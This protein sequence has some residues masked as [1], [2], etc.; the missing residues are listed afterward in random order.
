MLQKYLL[1][2]LPLLISFMLLGLATALAQTTIAQDTARM[3]VKPGYIS[4]KVVN[5]YNVPLKNARVAV[6]GTRDTTSTDRDGMFTI[7]ATAGN[8]L[9]VKAKGFN[10]TNY[11]VSK[12]SRAITIQ[13]GELYIKQ[14]E[15]LSVLYDTIKASENLSAISTVYTNQLTTT[16]AS[17]YTYALPGRLAGLYT[18]QNSGFPGAQTNSPT[19]TGLGGIQ[20]VFNA[21][22]S[23][24][25]NNGQISLQSRGSDNAPITVI[26]GVQR[27]LSSIDPES[28][29]SVS[30]LRDGLSTILLGVNSSNSVLLVTTKR[31]QIGKTLISGTAQYGLQQ[32]LGLPTPLSSFQYGYL[33]NEALLNDG[34]APLYT[35]AD[36]NAYKNQTDIYGHPDVNWFNTL[37]RKTSPL[38]SYKVNITGGNSVAKFIVSLN[39]FNQ[40]GLFKNDSSVPYNTNNG[41]NRYILNSDININATKN[42]NIDLQLFGRVQSIIYPGQPSIG[43]GGLLSTLYSIPNNAYPI[44]NADGSFPGSNDS[45]Y[46]NNIIAQS[47]FSG[48]TNTQNHD[49]LTNLDLKYNLG[50]VLKGLSVRGKGN[51]A[52]NSQ[53]F[54]D[55][56]LQNSVYQFNPVTNGYNVFGKTIAQSNSF[57]NVSNSRYAYGQAALAYNNSFGKNNFNSS[58][59]YDY[60]SV[61]LTYDL[62]RVFQNRAFNIAYNYDG[63]YFATG[64]VNN[65]SDDRYPPGNQSYFFYAGGLG[66]QMGKE[67]FMKNLTWISS[68]KWRATYANTG[69]D[70]LGYFD[71]RAT[72]EGGGNGYPQGTG[73]ITGNGYT[74]SNYIVNPNVRPE[75]AH[76][77]NIGTDI[78]FWDQKFLLTADYYNNRYYDLLQT[79]GKSSL[80]AGVPKFPSENIGINKYEGAEVTLTYQNHLNDFNYFITGNGNISASKRIYSDELQ[81]VYPWLALTGR[82]LR[83]GYGYIAEGFFQSQQEIN[84][85]AKYFNYT[86]KPGDIK[87]K[88]LN[89][90]GIINNFDVYPIAN[91]RPL[92]YY[93]LNL[94]FNYKGFNFSMLLQGVANNQIIFNQM[95]VTQGFDYKGFLSAP[96]G[97]AYT[98]ILNRWTPE[99]AA[100]ATSPR[101][102]AGP[103]G[104]NGLP[105]TFYLHSGNYVRLK[106]AEIGYTI[107]YRLTG[108]INVSSVRF[109]VNGLNLITVAG[110]KGIDPEVNGTAY[111]IQRVFNA[112]VNVKL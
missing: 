12:T 9:T 64:S 82:S 18:K 84:S 97:Q 92:I 28:I 38:Q 80:I 111:P 108:R 51:F 30:L 71:Y 49:I 68:W 13:V 107:P 87:Y 112:G 8:K 59:F 2:R 95:D 17:L 76:K 69:N 96:Y 24:N 55:R 77:I 43:I 62:P 73:Y 21:A 40:A 101:L 5:L 63:K 23:T 19:S 58:L 61:V 79:R 85:S 31:P 33:L 98:T 93:G 14:P 54:I 67:N 102:T 105:S 81:Q 4:G 110:Y 60:R 57:S 34:K 56:S 91:V 45:F 103:N 37:L 42:F 53:N 70:V 7:K 90:D 78:A 20:Y 15:Q 25:D 65:S 35:S 46:Q 16:P 72:F 74:E 39:Y 106:N 100:T 47:Q 109:F 99:N 6:I 86:A 94:G 11:R 44:R 10:V 66:W 88:D 26:D 1:K 89:G 41:L 52:I 75:R 36:L 22:S 104:N 3:A 29:E 27:E 48:Y 50:S 83:T 32:P